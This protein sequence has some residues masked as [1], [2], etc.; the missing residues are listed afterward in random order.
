[1]PKIP[2]ADTL[3]ASDALSCSVPHG[4]S[5]FMRW[6][7][8][9]ETANCGNRFNITLHYTSHFVY[10]CR[11]PYSG[12]NQPPNANTHRVAVCTQQ[13]HSYPIRDLANRHTFV[14]NSHSDLNGHR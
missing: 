12:A 9:Y 2:F 14:I 6:N 8:E 5:V 1:V 7:K 4:Y 11:L 10:R 3:D 13:S